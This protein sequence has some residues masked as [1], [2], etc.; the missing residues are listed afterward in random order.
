MRTTCL[1]NNYNYGRFVADAI[2]SALRQSVAFDEIIVVDDGSTDNSVEIITQHFGHHEK[3]KLLRKENGGQLSCFNEGLAA[4]GGD[5]IFFLDADDLYQEGYLERALDVYAGNSDCDFLFC[6]YQEFGEVD[7][8][9]R[10]YPVDRSFGRTVLLTYCL[11]KWIG[12][13]TSALSIKTAALNRILPCP[14]LQDW[15]TRADD[16]LVY[17]AGL[18]GA[19]KYYLAEPCVRYRI[20]GNNHWFGKKFSADQ[21][22]QHEAAVGRLFSFY[23]ERQKYSDDFTK[24]TVGEFRTYAAPT[25]QE[26]CRYIRICQNADLSLWEKFQDI[27]ALGIYYCR[28]KINR[29]PTDFKVF[30]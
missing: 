13:P 6:A 30:P 24:R 2:Y 7:N 22:N 5:V 25:F 9:V 23:I 12:S 3:V 27:K 14:Y 20:H 4:A 18:V 26:L 8:I 11:K 16:C 15:R 19:K 28:S 29:R 17:G 21:I 1:I 10:K